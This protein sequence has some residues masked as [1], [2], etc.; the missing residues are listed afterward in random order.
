MPIEIRELVIRA[1]VDPAG[2]G[3]ANASGGCGVVPDR[4]SPGGGGTADAATSADGELVQACVR[5]VMRVLER[6]AER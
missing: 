6:K 4:K 3:G 1:I 5:E 2:N